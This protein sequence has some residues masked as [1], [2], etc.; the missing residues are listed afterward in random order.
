[1]ERLS[2]E[3]IARGLAL[4]GLAAVVLGLWAASTSEVARAI[5]RGRPLTGI[6][7]GI[8]KVETARHSDTLM[9]WNYD[10]VHG[11][12][13]A[14]SVPRDTRIDLPGYRFRRVNEVFAYHY[15][16][17][18]DADKAAKEVLSAVTRIISDS[19]A[20]L[21]PRYYLQVDYGGFREIIDLLG[22]VDV[23][24]DEPMH[25]DDNA[26]GYHI[27]REPGDYHLNGQEA[28][29]Y[30]RFRG[31]SGDR[32]RILRQME[33][34]KAVLAKASSPL[35]YVKAPELVS[36]VL[37]NI[38]TNLRPWDVVFLAL[39]LKHLR[40]DRFN[41]RLL[42]GHPSGP[43]WEMD[44]ERIALVV[45]QMTGELKPLES[46]EVKMESAAT[47]VR[48]WNGSGRK[49]VALEVTRRLRLAGFDVLEWGNYDLRQTKTR[50]MDRVGDFDKAQRVARALGVDSVFSDINPKLRADVEVI[51]GDD[52]R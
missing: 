30:V 40:A 42:P 31:K 12:L 41:P 38:H 4:A 18:R 44:R 52:Y 39:E 51:V 37:A 26:G 23:H 11:R 32:G 17:T 27:H 3:K 7:M 8:D 28:L 10:P 9:I 33:F 21:A 48:V 1:M 2:Q 22:G 47:T 5:G 46:T 45:R 43:Y 16:V 24:V 29:E 19:G 35:L 34:V 50:V 6:V 25:Y 49:G 13:D 14:L 15:G 36:T 20:D